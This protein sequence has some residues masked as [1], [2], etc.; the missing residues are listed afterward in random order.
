MLHVKSSQV[1]RLS[2]RLCTYCI[3]TFVKLLSPQN[4]EPEFLSSLVLC[5]FASLSGDPMLPIP[6]ILYLRIEHGG[7]LTGALEISH[8]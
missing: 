1:V 5:T 7:A 4:H 2:L 8:F 3:A 6:Q